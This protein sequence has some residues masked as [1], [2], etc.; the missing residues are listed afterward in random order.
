MQIFPA[1]IVR[2][3]SKYIIIN[4]NQSQ[5]LPNN[6][7]L[8]QFLNRCVNCPKSYI[9]KDIPGGLIKMS[10][11]VIV[12]KTSSFLILTTYNKTTKTKMQKTSK[13][14]NCCVISTRRVNKSDLREKKNI[15]TYH[16][17]MMIVVCFYV[18]SFLYY[19]PIFQFNS[20]S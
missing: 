18:F 2:T 17:I 6:M 15:S 1:S 14:G 9:S 3:K 8:I 20:K 4:N 13:N 11:T 10:T 19:L 5:Y 12:V 7:H 16:D